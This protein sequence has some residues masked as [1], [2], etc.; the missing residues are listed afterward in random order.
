MKEERDRILQEEVTKRVD[1]IPEED[2]AL[3]MSSPSPSPHVTGERPERMKSASSRPSS[4]Q[5]RPKSRQSK[6]D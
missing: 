4:R 5:E 6:K 2:E 3:A 1:P